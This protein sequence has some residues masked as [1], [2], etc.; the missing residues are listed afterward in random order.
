MALNLKDEALKKAVDEVFFEGKSRAAVLEADKNISRRS[1]F[2]F[3]IEVSIFVCGSYQ[4]I[5]YY[6]I[7]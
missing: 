1:L 2:K 6:I 7:S 4:L 3:V 5:S